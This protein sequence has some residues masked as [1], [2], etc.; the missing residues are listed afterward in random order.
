MYVVVVVL[1][2]FYLRLSSDF[3][4]VFKKCGYF[5]VTGYN[6]LSGFSEVKNSELRQLIFDDDDGLLPMLLYLLRLN[7]DIGC[8]VI[9]FL[10]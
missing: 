4:F 9:E 7:L 2:W 8:C 6:E 1:C 3:G 5:S 10:N